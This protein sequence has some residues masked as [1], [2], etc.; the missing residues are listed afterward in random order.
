MHTKMLRIGQSH[1]VAN[2]F[3]GQSYALLLL[4]EQH[5]RTSRVAPVVRTPLQ[6]LYRLS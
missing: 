1:V 4:V 2:Q 6:S 5:P 3:G